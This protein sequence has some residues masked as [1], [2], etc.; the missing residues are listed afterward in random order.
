[1][2]IKDKRDKIGQPVTKKSKQKGALRTSIRNDYI[3]SRLSITI[4][5]S[6]LSLSY[7]RIFLFF[8][9][10]SACRRRGIT[11]DI[12]RSKTRREE[13]ARVKV[14][15]N[16]R[17]HTP[18]F[19]FAGF[20]FVKKKKKMSRPPQLSIGAVHEK[21]HDKNLNVRALLLSLLLF[22]LIFFPP[23]FIAGRTRSRSLRVGLLRNDCDGR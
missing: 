16:T 9:L 12:K 19:G 15:H 2:I 1:M 17:R 20:P 6:P 22:H 23:P 11:A 21:V 7:S 3:P 13:I 8:F 5:S 10:L 18:N 14:Q 4:T